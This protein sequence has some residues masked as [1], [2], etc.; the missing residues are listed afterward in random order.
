MSILK[1]HDMEKNNSNS[2]HPSYLNIFRSFKLA[3]QP[4]KIIFAMLAVIAIFLAGAVMDLSKTACF[5]PETTKTQIASP[6]QDNI[7]I[8]KYPTELHC[9]LANPEKYND[10]I[11]KFDQPNS[12]T[13]V[14]RI[15][16]NFLGRRLNDT[17]IA[18]LHLDLK[19]T[20][21]N[22]AYCLNSLIW[23]FK[24]HAIYA[25]IYTIF[26]LAAIAFAGA[27]ICR[28]AAL[29]LATSQKPGLTEAYH[30]A[31]QKFKHFYLAPLLPILIAA[32]FGIILTLVGVLSNIPW[33]GDIIFGLSVLPVIFLGFLIA[34]LLT[35]TAAGLGIMFPTIAFEYSDAFDAFC[36][37][38]TYIFIRPWKTAFYNFIALAYALITYLFIRLCAFLT[39][40]IARAFLDLG[41][42][43]KTSKTPSICKI[44]AIWQKPAFFD[45]WPQTQDVQKNIA[46]NFSA[47]CIH[48]SC[49]LYTS[50]S[51]RDGLLSRMPS[52]A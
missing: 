3:I 37:S 1:G 22:L 52:S 35:C 8:S 16:W 38:F 45:L 23:A 5:V 46:E 14:A 31:K 9:Y 49:L 36:R 44:D 6:P 18:L 32:I 17:I 7:Q 27:A 43:A 11:E 48:L 30:F 51:P 41:M 15:F 21:K 29:Q 26:N 4:T 19:N 12:K 24:Y 50:P 2:D 28:I 10:Y 33:F 20:Y 25:V 34:I 13:G 40:T 42:W 39:I 47:F